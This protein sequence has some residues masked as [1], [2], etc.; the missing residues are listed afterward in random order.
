MSILVRHYESGDRDAVISL[1]NDVFPNSTGHNAPATSLQRKCDEDDGLFFVAELDATVVGTVM[2]GYDGHRGWIYSLAVT[3]TQQRR[4]IGSTLMRHAEE[5]L[6][7]LGCPKI[8]LQVRA[9]NDSIVAFYRSLGYGTEERISM[10]KRLA[11]TVDLGEPAEAR[12]SQSR[13]I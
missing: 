3:P 8:N 2:A 12:E 7:N 11:S 4:G 1:W 13:V 5:T 6:S 10:G 9:Q